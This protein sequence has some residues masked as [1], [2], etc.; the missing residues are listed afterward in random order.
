MRVLVAPDAFKGS[1]TAAQA[2]AALRR[3]WL[4]VRPHDDVV[5]LPLADGGEGTLDVVA[6]V[7]DGAER[8]GLTV[9]GPAGPVQG[10]WLL[11]PGGTAVVELALASG[12]PLH[13]A[14]DPLGAHTTGFGELLAA[15]AS[16]PRVEEVVAALGGSASTDGAAGALTALGARF[17][18]DAG[19][20]LA[21]GGGALSQLAAVDTTGLLQPP[22]RG[23][24]LL[25]DV[26]AP[27][28]GPDG[29]AAQFGPQKGAHPA[30]VVR[31]E[32]GL[33]RLA[34]LV[35]PAGLVSNLAGAGAAGGSGFGLAALWGAD[36]ARGAA[37]V[38]E[39]TRLAEQVSSYDLVVTG[40]G[41][42]DAQS[43]RGK[44]VGQV[45]ETAGDLCVPVWACVGSQ[46][47]SAG[48]EGPAAQ[49]RGVTELARMAGTTEA[50]VRE[51]H[52]WLEVA[53]AHAAQ[54]HR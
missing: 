1:A 50:A 9:N 38:A 12:L 49:L 24:R 53:G 36:L 40:E 7:I 2:A 45:C 25:V 20:P 22:R 29:A 51:V 46:S 11:L 42:L 30:D 27:L 28:L 33:A 10:S 41:R 34:A 39:L 48:V 37:A 15:A 54:A 18:D 16:D 6:S 23:V 13:P 17:L 43:F 4:S 44:V 26:D 47:A 5:E 35:D 19:E 52:R 3:G 32:Q 8:V 14:P 31:L 21:R